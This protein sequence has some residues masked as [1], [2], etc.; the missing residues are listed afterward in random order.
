M[1]NEQLRCLTFLGS[2]A[3]ADD[4]LRPTPTPPRR[5]REPDDSGVPLSNPF[6]SYSPVPSVMQLAGNSSASE[7]QRAFQ[8]CPPQSLHLSGEQER[9]YLPPLPPPPP[10]PPTHP[11]LL[12]LL[13]SVATSLPPITRRRERDGGRNNLKTSATCTASSRVGSTARHPVSLFLLHPRLQPKTCPPL[14]THTHTH[15]HTH[16]QEQHSPFH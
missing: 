14:T 1:D 15:T 12:I 10:P 16:T 8:E 5:Y 2:R 6:L 4:Q 3:Q 13:M 11:S 9:Q 7:D